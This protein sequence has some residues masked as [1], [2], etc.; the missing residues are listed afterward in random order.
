MTLALDPAR[1]ARIGRH[2]DET[3]VAP[4][5]LAGVDIAIWRGGEMAWRHVSGFADAE[6]GRPLGEDAIWRLNE[7]TYSAVVRGRK[8]NTVLCVS[9]PKSASASHAVSRS[10]QEFMSGMYWAKRSRAAPT[11]GE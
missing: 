4:G 10:S 1:L 6:R 8:P 3:Y 11:V 7:Y 5:K 2:F 9:R